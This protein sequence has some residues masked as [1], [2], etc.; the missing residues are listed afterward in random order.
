MS[1]K[2][3]MVQHGDNINA[4]GNKKTGFYPQV[5]RSVTKTTE[6][7]A[8]NVARGKRLQA[9]EM[10]G[11][12]EL[13]FACIEDELLKGN[14]VCFDGFGTFALSAECR[15]VDDPTKIR[16]ES[17]MVKRVTFTPSKPLIKRL[18]SAKFRKA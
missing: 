16:A 5:V 10:K 17:I 4:E 6:D 13:L 15:A 2:Y 8:L 1:I 11:N 18:K 3:K 12:I 9:L 14:N 7:M